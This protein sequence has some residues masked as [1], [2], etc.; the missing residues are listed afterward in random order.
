MYTSARTRVPVQEIREYDWPFS[1]PLLHGTAWTLLPI[2]SIVSRS[3]TNGM[4]HVRFGTETLAVHAKPG[5]T[6]KSLS[7]LIRG[8]IT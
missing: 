5:R 8:M 4:P 6:V 7:A 1:F 3:A 2:S